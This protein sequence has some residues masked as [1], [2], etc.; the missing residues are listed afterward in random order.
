MHNKERYRKLC[1]EK[2]IPLF[3]QAWW[4]DTVCTPED[5][6]WDVLLCEENGEI[7]GAMPYHIIKKWGFKIILQ[8]P[9]AQYSG[10]WIDYPE[11]C[12]LH[13]RYSLE[14]RVMDNLIDQLETLNI[15]Y[16]SQNF[17]YSFTNWQPFYWRG[18]QQTTRY[19]Y[20]LKN[21]ADIDM[22]FNNIS[23]RYRKNLRKCEKELTVDFNLSAEEFY[24]LHKSSLAEKNDRIAYSKQLFLSIYQATIKTEQSKIIAV[25]DKNNN[26]L[27]AVFFVWDTNSGYN[28]ITARTKIAKSNDAL[29]YMIWQ[30]IKYLNGKT[31]D[32]DFEGSMIEGVATKNQRFGAKQVPYFKI[33]KSYSKLFSLAFRI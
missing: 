11:D 1:E 15:L 9:F 4:L 21:I 27:S 33:S 2:N 18:F 29:I 25:R 13:K 17:H 6:Q 19:T 5:K 31:K 16:Y 3:M 26:L 28:L 8:A 22:I 30:T 24:D 32:Y 20:I 12:K 23:P 7:I 14:K 10:I